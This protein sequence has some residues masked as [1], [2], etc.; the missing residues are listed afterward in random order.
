MDR[1][2]VARL[3]GLLILGLAVSGA[4]S[5]PRAY[6]PIF[7]ATKARSAAPDSRNPTLAR[8]LKAAGADGRRRD[9]R[10]RLASAG[11]SV[12]AIDPAAA[13]IDRLR[14]ADEF[15]LDGVSARHVRDG[16]GLPMVAFRDLPGDLDDRSG[17]ERFLPN[18]LA[19]AVTA[20]LRTGPAGSS[21][22]ELADP[23]NRPTIAVEGV[24]PV[25]LAADFTTPLMAT[26]QQPSLQA[27]EPLGVVNPET[28]WRRTG[29]VMLAPYQ[30]GKVPV[31]L[32]HG[33]WSDPQTWLTM[34]NEFEADPAIRGRYQFW[35]AFHAT[36]YAPLVSAWR[37][38][39]ALD[40]LRDAIDPGRAD[41][42]LDQMVVVSHSMGGVIAKLLVQES[43]D[44]V[45]QALLRVPMDQLDLGGD[46]R[47]FLEESLYFRPNPSIRRLVL[48]AAPHR[49]S[50]L[51]NEFDARY[52]AV[53]LRRRGPGPDQVRDLVRRNGREVL[54]PGLGRSPLSGVGSLSVDQ[55]M[56][57]AFNRLAFAPGLA[58]H[59]I[60]AVEEDQLGRPIESTSD[61]VV[62]YPSA[63]LAGLPET[64]V[65]GGHRG[66]A[67][68][69]QVIDEVRRVLE[70]HAAELERLP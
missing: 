3:A 25:P 9:W 37:I 40:G 35:A 48:I 27:F 59:S 45:R 5:Q 1:R 23:R 12:V 68:N 8:L 18:H 36:G 64:F 31:L 58:I 4:C 13:G 7:S 34:L 50:A 47:R 32:V 66:L 26:L 51:A 49:G 6:R 2:R 54:Q 57:L 15:E 20:V 53:L 69:R 67:S 10:D 19:T 70:I 46:S 11:V 42:A 61:G 17:V 16:W 14:P 52:G 29:I 39:R 24:G 65:V 62:A 38:R 33:L 60:I 30:P 21:V 41:P 22:L 63:H 28:I 56:L 43:G 44:E 55:P